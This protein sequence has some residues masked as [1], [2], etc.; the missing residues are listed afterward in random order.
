MVLISGRTLV[1]I[2]DNE[3][4]V[5]LTGIGQSQERYSLKVKY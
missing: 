1:R 5:P 3:M 4:N 2:D